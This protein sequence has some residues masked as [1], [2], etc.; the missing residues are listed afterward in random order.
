MIKAGRS[1]PFKETVRIPKILPDDVTALHGYL[2]TVHELILEKGRE[3]G[4]DWEQE[5]AARPELEALMLLE[6]EI[7]LKVA[8]T[9]ADCLS[10]VLQKF[11][12]WDMLRS[13]DA[14][15][16]ET[17]GRDKVVWSI[18]KDIEELIAA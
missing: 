8:E 11:A 1:C 5:R 16:E 15:A 9:R 2:S 4:E 13:A 12:I 17:A 10:A 14:D 3:I 6:A 18:R 7:S